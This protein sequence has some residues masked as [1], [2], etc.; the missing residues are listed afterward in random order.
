MRENRAGKIAAFIDQLGK[1]PASLEEWES[2][3][4]S[5]LPEKGT[6]NRDGSITSEFRNG[7]KI[8]VEAK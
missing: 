3:V 4:W 7:K 5:L 8:K 2:H 1:A 6:V